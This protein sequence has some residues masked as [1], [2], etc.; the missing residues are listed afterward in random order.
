MWSEF[1]TGFYFW[2]EGQECV[3][4]IS[5]FYLFFFNSFAYICMEATLFQD[6]SSGLVYIGEVT[7]RWPGQWGGAC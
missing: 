2:V 5:V 4:G 6:F 1:A 3:D 7:C